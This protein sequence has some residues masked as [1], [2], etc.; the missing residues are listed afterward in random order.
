[1]A[2]ELQCPLG[3]VEISE[4]GTAWSDISAFTR[5]I[6]P[7]ER[8]RPVAIFKTLDGIPKSCIGPADPVDIEL[9][10]LYSDADTEPYAIIRGAHYDETPLSIR[11]KT[12]SSTKQWTAADVTVPTFDEPEINADS[13]D[14]VFTLVTLSANVIDW[15]LAATP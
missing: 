6:D 1:M 12:A 13:T 7:G 15:A 3:L 9:E 14:G 4:D 2:A 10:F 5:R 11:W 8:S